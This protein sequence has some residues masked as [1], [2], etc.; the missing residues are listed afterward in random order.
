MIE[1]IVELEGDVESILALRLQLTDHDVVI[2]E[3]APVIEGDARARVRFIDEVLAIHG[4]E[5]PAAGKIVA[6]ELRHIERRGRGLRGGKWHHRNRYGL[7]LAASH[8]DDKFRPGSRADQE[9]TDH[10]HELKLLN[11]WA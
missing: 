3:P 8:F 11:H 5:P 7:L 10:G 6:H 1:H 2:V 9:K 4:L